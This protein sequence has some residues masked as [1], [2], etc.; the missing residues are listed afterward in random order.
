M[1]GLLQPIH[2]FF[3]VLI[4]L[5][6]FGPGKLPRIGDGIRHFISG[7]SDGRTVMR[8]AVFMAKGVDPAVGRDVG[9]TLPD[10]QERPRRAWTKVL[11]STLAGNSLYFLVMPILPPAARLGEGSKHGVP[12]LIDVWCCLLAFGVLTYIEAKRTRKPPKN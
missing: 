6:L 12:V 4:V 2:I 8:R 1:P 7:L 5:I 3:L 9:D 10:E 11:F